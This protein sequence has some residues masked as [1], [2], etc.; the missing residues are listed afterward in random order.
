MK[1]LIKQWRNAFGSLFVHQ[2]T[3][4]IKLPSAI[5]IKSKLM[6]ALDKEGHSTKYI[7]FVKFAIQNGIWMEGRVRPHQWPKD[8]VCD[9]FLY[10]K[11]NLLLLFG[12]Y[13][14][15]VRDM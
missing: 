5:Q 11:N 4:E 9:H 7:F 10:R 1:Y 8:D 13:F 2:K 3:K 15:G 6:E 14:N 12:F